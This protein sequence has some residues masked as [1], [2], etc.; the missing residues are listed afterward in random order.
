MHLKALIL[1]CTSSLSHTHTP[2]PAVSLW[3]VGDLNNLGEKGRERRQHLPQCR[4]YRGKLVFCIKPSNRF[5]IFRHS[6]AT[7]W[8]PLHVRTG[9]VCEATW[10]TIEKGKN[11]HLVWRPHII[12]TLFNSVATGCLCATNYWWRIIISPPI[13][14]YHAEGFLRSSSFHLSWFVTL[15]ARLAPCISVL[16]NLIHAAYLS[17]SVFFHTLTNAHTLWP[18]KRLEQW[19]GLPKKP[20]RENLRGWLESF[21][22][23]KAGR[24]ACLLL[25]IPHLLDKASQGSSAVLNWC[26]YPY[27]YRSSLWLGERGESDRTGSYSSAHA[28]L[29]ILIHGRIGFLR[30]H[31][32]S[33]A[34]HGIFNAPAT[35]NAAV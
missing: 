31:F 29:L 35:T 22:S 28:Y 19:W 4:L 15:L 11:R 18:Q 7:N 6:S 20:F 14:L 25:V 9:N 17:H 33:Y 21:N 23:N 24:E 30:S 26:T 3:N 10:L 34:W 27:L 16:A 32:S 13:G 1:A 2:C 5:V 8:T 12:M